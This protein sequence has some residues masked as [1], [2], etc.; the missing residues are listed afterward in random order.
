MHV[1]GASGT[2]AA[3]TGCQRGG[4][5]RLI[6][7][8]EPEADVSPG[9]TVEYSTV[10]RECPAGCGMIARVRD[11]RAF[12][13]RGNPDHP[14]NRGALCMRGTAS[15]QGLYNPDRIRQPLARDTYGRLTP[16]S[17]REAEDRLDAALT[18]LRGKRAAWIGRLETG[19]MDR[20]ITSWL[21]AIAPG[22]TFLRHEPFA[23][24]PLRAA[25]A[26]VFGTAEIPQYRIDR[27]RMLI[28]FGADFLETWVSNVEYTRQ[29]SEWRQARVRGD[30][31]A[32]Y[33]FIAPRL[34]LTGANAD[35]WVGIRP[36]T[37]G[38]VARALEHA[39]TAAHRS[40][41][42]I[43]QAG[44]LAGA[45]GM[46][47]IGPLADAA[48]IPATL[49]ERLGR[50]FAAGSPSL[51]LP[52]GFAGSGE[53]AAESEAAILRLNGAAGNIGATVLRGEPHAL[54]AASRYADLIALTGA[55]NA[56]DIGAVFLYHANPSYD[57]PPGAGFDGAL[58]RVPHVVSFASFP[59][60][61]TGSPGETGGHASLVLPDHT[62]LEAWGEYSPRPDTTGIQQPVVAPLF[63][64]RLTGDV[65]LESA[66]R[67][68]HD[69]GP[70]RFEDYLK[71]EHRLDAAAWITTL[72]AGGLFPGSGT[73]GEGSRQR[74]VFRSHGAAALAA[75]AAGS[76]APKRP[77]GMPRPDRPTDLTRKASAAHKTSGE[78]PTVIGPPETTLTEQP[79]SG[80][81]RAAGT[82]VAGPGESGERS[83]ASSPFTAAGG[84]GRPSPASKPPTAPPNLSTPITP[85]PIRAAHPT[86]STTG[87][88]L[89]IFPSIQFFDGRMANRPWSQE[90]P[91][92]TAKA[93]WGSWAEIH[94]DRARA[95]AVR[96]GQVLS[97]TT[98]SGK[99]E[100]PAL[101]S[102]WVHPDV[103]AVMI[104]QGHTTFGRYA[105]GVGANPLTLLDGR[106]DPA[107]GG[108]MVGGVP[109]NV[110]RIPVTRPLA[111]LQTGIRQIGE[112]V[113]HGMTI[114]EMDQLPANAR[115]A[116]LRD[117]NDHDSLY[118]LHYHPDRH[119]GMVIDLDRCVGCN[120]CVAA[121]YA[122]NNVPVVGHDECARGREMSWIRIENYVGP[123]SHEAGPPV[124]V[125]SEF[126]TAA[127]TRGNSMQVD[128][129]FLPMLCQQCDNAPCEYACP[130]YATVHDNEGLN[131]MIYNRCIGTRFCSNNCPYKVRRF[132]WA[133]N[134]FPSPLD[135]QLNPDVIHRTKGVMEK[136]TFCVQRIRAREIEAD[137]TGHPIRDGE[138][139]TAC[140]QAC[141]ADAIIFGNLNDKNSEVH[142]MTRSPRGYAALADLNT[143]PNVTYLARVRQT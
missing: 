67:L 112:D 106:A 17:W 43:T 83:G 35:E 52:I 138:I 4:P 74:A 44:P 132:N 142:R 33:V 3:L 125:E 117:R 22:S 137:S 62:D 58:A 72:Q 123:A 104:G 100:V 92:S 61:T 129:R 90:I 66:R 108:P 99:V 64:T 77:K 93:V 91:D 97:I 1:I 111:V 10:C 110:A 41:A 114:R 25:H 113:A 60:E 130:V 79:L 115:G 51:A 122:E 53:A 30:H 49:V 71:S 121:C 2:A 56:G 133:D 116:A 65:L 69:L 63:E 46:S 89:H 19:A 16:I 86:E 135:E 94:P 50:E 40:A 54:S 75:G 28:S 11:G 134:N 68:G 15:L 32:R 84:I 31:R 120:A 36:G 131:L 119:W 141:P 82:S 103:V 34:S 95:L 38:L 6:P 98:A 48:G 101:I 88:F 12:M 136:C 39:V 57:L 96:S 107:S 78:P 8:L 9:A 27:A 102:D 45:E 128:V 23:Y 126:Q 105:S 87:L 13:V 47:E 14:I 124:P 5:E 7:Y 59:D 55:M 29:F 118:H 18:A 127:E 37:E 80:M 21:A 76:E 24:E 42:G 70:A 26:R 81:E 139:A 143:Y 73:A 109:V 140:M 85:S 20:L